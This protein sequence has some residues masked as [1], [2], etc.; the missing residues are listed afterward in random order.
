MGLIGILFALATGAA[1]CETLQE[2]VARDGIVMVEADD[3]GMTAAIRRAQKTLPTFLALARKP[4][5]TTT[6][7]AVKV[8]VLD[9]DEAEY[10][11]ITPFK[12]FNGK[13]SGQIDNNPQLVKSVKFGQTISFLEGEIV[14]WLYIDNGRMQGN[15]T[16]CVL[17]KR[18]SRREADAMMKRFGL[19]CS[20]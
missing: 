4:P 2:R 7:F 6:D 16:L 1:H 9:G 5:R 17:L 3:P 15:F 10:F 8:V 20:P 12:E 18:E 14:D 19:E 13:F 11:W